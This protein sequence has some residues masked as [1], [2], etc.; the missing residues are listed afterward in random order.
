MK[1]PTSAEKKRWWLLCY[2]N[3]SLEKTIKT[4]AQ[5]HEACASN[6]SPLFS[7]LSLAIHAF[8]ARPFKN[9]RGVGSLS[10]EIIP[11]DARGIHDWLI[12]FRDSVLAHTDANAAEVS[13]CPMHEV[14]Y[15][16]L[17]GKRQFLTCDPSARPE[18]YRDV[19]VHSERLRRIIL[20]EIVYIHTLYDSLIPKEDGDYLLQFKESDPLFRPYAMQDQAVLKYV[21][22]PKNEA[23]NALEPSRLLV[24]ISAISVLRTGTDRAKQPAG[25][26]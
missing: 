14:V 26:A 1:N 3:T 13:G 11:A 9:N 6:T 23:Y 19:A 8:Y 2:A 10:D 4:C 17:R 24:T 22:K 18:S 16:N 20:E 12:H 7:P 21:P 15:S 25:S 5:L